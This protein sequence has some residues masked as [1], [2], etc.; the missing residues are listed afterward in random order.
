LA[1]LIRGVVGFDGKLSFDTSRPDGMPE[2]SLDSSGLAALGW[3]A[4]VGLEEGLRSMY[5]WW[6]EHGEI[7]QHDARERRACVRF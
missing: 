6:L 3:R 2:K 7:D 5:A 1:E 4:R